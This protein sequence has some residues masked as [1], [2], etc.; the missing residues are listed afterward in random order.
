[1]S[2]HRIALGLALI[3][4]L[5]VAPSAAASAAA[6][7]QTWTHV[8]VVD[9]LCIAKVK[10][11]PDAHTRECAIQCVKGGYGL[12]A[13]DGAYLK[14]DAKGNAMALEGL[15]A[16]KKADH[17]RAKVTGERDGETIKVSSIAF[18]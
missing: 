8:S 9:S 18:E 7:E 1:M 2:I 13:E 3:L 16:S 11:N 5:V 6:A 15:R 14:F 12:V 4:P 10:G 17:L